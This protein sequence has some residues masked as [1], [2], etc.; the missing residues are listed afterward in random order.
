MLRWISRRHVGE[1]YCKDCWQ[2]C[3]FKLRLSYNA[4][5]SYMFNVCVL[6]FSIYRAIDCSDRWMDVSGRHDPAHATHACLLS[7]IAHSKLL[8]VSTAP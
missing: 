4:V 3:H 5:Q 7:P 8:S 1:T 6:L 2:Y